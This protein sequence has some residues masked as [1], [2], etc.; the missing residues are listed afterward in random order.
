MGAELCKHDKSSSEAKSEI[1]AKMTPG[2]APKRNPQNSVVG[3]SDKNSNATLCEEE[4]SSGLKN[5]FDKVDVDSPE[6]KQDLKDA[7]MGHPAV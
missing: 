1:Q 3:A 2:K 5:I 6:G 4:F 7:V